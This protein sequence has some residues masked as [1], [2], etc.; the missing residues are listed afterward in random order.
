M[1]HRRRHFL[2]LVAQAF[3]CPPVFRR[4]QAFEFLT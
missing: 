2:Q 1:K 3:S 4:A